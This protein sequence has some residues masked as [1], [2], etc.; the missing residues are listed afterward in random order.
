MVQSSWISPEFARPGHE[1]FHPNL[2]QQA[3]RLTTSR[4]VI[5]SNPRGARVP[6]QDSNYCAAFRRPR[7]AETQI[8]IS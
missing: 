6:P 8:E 3:T 1:S 2:I 4:K 7:A 5:L